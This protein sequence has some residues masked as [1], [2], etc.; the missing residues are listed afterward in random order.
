MS[1]DF[2]PWKT[3]GEPQMVLSDISSITLEELNRNK[4]IEEFTDLAN[5]FKSNKLKRLKI[6]KLSADR[7]LIPEV[8]NGK[9]LYLRTEPVQPIY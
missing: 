3:I 7:N 1:Y 9:K 2:K 4:T 5:R 8:Q 6:I